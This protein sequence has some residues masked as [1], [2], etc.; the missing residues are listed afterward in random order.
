MDSW[1]KLKGVS[2]KSHKSNLVKLGRGRK[3]Q[4]GNKHNWKSRKGKRKKSVSAK[5][6]K[7]NDIMNKDVSDNNKQIAGGERQSNVNNASKESVCERRKKKR[8]DQKRRSVS[9]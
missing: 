8:P 7:A 5:N 4:S 9:N 1:L 2:N 6:R 3:K